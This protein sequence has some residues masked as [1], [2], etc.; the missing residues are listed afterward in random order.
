MTLSETGEVHPSEVVTI[1][2]YVASVH[3]ARFDKRPVILTVS[4]VPVINTLSGSRVNIQTPSFGKPL[5]I[6]L[7]VLTVFV[8]CIT[9]PIT[10]AVGVN[11]WGSIVIQ[12]GGET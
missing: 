5:R 6:T 3:F 1:K 10:G 7:P 4:P 12:I 2:V 9:S 11:G 8:G